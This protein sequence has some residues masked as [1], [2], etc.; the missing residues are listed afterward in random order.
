MPSTIRVF[1]VFLASPSDVSAD[2][3]LIAQAIEELNRMTSYRGFRFELVRWETHSTPAIAKKYPQQIIN[4]QLLS[5]VDIMIAV[6]GSR[7]G[8]PTPMAPSGTVEEIR[9][10]INNINHPMKENRLLVFFKR[11][12]VDVFDCDLEQ[13]RALRDFRDELQSSA[14][15]YK[16]YETDSTLQDIVRQSLNRI[17]DLNSGHK[18]DTETNK[19]GD[20]ISEIDDLGLFDHIQMFNTGAADFGKH[21]AEATRLI[22]DLGSKTT[23]TTESLEAAQIIGSTEQILVAINNQADWMDTYSDSMSS[24]L[25]LAQKS[26]SSAF[27]HALEVVNLQ[28]EDFG[29]DMAKAQEE[30]LP[31]IDELDGILLKAREPFQGYRL[32]V[33]KIPRF[34]KRINNSKRKLLLSLDLFDE[35]LDQ[36]SSSILAIKKRLTVQAS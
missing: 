29:S 36:T 19:I 25:S 7:L 32:A 24:Q 17:V 27:N 35:L 1:K 15:L 6:F 31:G 34:N 28:L 9:T 22:I 4:I 5:D 11:T 2:R 20:M 23:S 30:W 13:L 8:N 12:R 16:E 3:E 26:M 18:Q 14:V 33:E 21:L 10:I